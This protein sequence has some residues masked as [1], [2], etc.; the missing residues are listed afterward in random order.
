MDSNKLSESPLLE[1]NLPD[2][3]QIFHSLFV[4]LS[5]YQYTIFNKILL[6]CVSY[7]MGSM[8]LICAI[9]SS[10]SRNHTSMDFG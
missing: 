2:S 3:A 7:Y 8:N 10:N 5:L 1:V 9:E 6:Q 4:V